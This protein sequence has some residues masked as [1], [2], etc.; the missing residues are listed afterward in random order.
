M[1]IQQLLD[2]NQCLDAGPV[3]DPV[4]EQQPLLMAPTKAGDS[5]IAMVEGGAQSSSGRSLYVRMAR[6]QN[7]TRWLAMIAASSCTHTSL[8][9]IHVRM[10]I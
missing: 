10:L 5:E 3:S 7:Q 8:S 1:G 9:V 4:S 6:L 2:C